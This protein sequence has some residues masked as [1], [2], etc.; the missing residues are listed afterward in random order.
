MAM[1]VVGGRIIAARR[2]EELTSV[3]AVRD[4]HEK[5]PHVY[6]ILLFQRRCTVTTEI[7]TPVNSFIK[8]SQNEQNFDS[9]LIRPSY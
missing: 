6:M 2:R 9:I 5:P 7:F 4:G 8:S 1:A 3:T